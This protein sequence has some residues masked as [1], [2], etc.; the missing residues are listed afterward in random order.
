MKTIIFVIYY[1][2]VIFL[3]V[4]CSYLVF[5]KGASGWWY[6]LAVLMSQIAPTI[7]TTRKD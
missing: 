2:Y 1:L 6:L 3:L 4:G 7:T 5:W